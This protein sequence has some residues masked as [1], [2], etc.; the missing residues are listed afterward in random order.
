MND[1]LAVPALRALGL[2]KTYIDGALQVSV[3][4]GLDF[5]VEAGESVAPG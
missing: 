3:L 4:K 1:V 2:V 5:T